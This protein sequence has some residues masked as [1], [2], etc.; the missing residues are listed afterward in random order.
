MKVGIA[1]FDF[2]GANKGCEA[3]TH[4]FLVM[5]QRLIPNEKID[6]VNFAY[7]D[8]FG[9]FPE[10]YPDI[11]FSRVKTN[12]KS[13]KYWVEAL[14]TMKS[15]ALFFDATY[16]DSFSDIYGKKWNIQTNFIKQL[17]LLSGTPL[18]LLPQTY[19]PFEDKSMEKW[20][21]KLIKGASLAYS[22]DELSAE[23]IFNKTGI[24]IKVTSDMAFKLPYVCT[25][26][27]DQRG[28]IKIG[29][30]ISSLLWEGKWAHEN[31]FGLTV[32]YHQYHE[33]LLSYLL[34]DDRFEIHFIPHV[35][36][37][38]HM[39]ARENDYRVC[40]QM[41]E[42]YHE[43]IAAGKVIIA[44]PF[45]D[46]IQA[47]SYIS[48]MNIFVGS[49]MHATIGAISSGVATIP[50]SYSRKFEGL[51]GRINYPY[52]VS[53]REIET[54]EA[55]ETTRQWIESANELKSHGKSSVQF[56][57][58]DLNEFEKEISNLLKTR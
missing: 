37:L 34:K 48:D 14:K 13:P 6:I 10:M 50:F 40:L 27:C 54:Q 52:V 4:T 7:T 3:L 1:G 9:K 38:E 15:C 25:K 53:A 36:D 26:H 11:S 23:Y 45:E 19:G 57:V 43:E 49:R 17:V 16:G 29:I 12:I 32:D 18:V 21:M 20:A 46:P 5:L 24:H 39:D 44:P 8:T 55:L 47:K 28:K 42:R 41:R 58:D 31:H 56:A 33:E 51:Y 30:N 2:V 22:R 35:I